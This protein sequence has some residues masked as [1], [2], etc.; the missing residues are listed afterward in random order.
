MGFFAGELEV[1]LQEHNPLP[2]ESLWNVL[3][4]LSVH[5]QQTER[6]QQAAA[7]IGQVATLP[8]PLLLQLR[9]ELNLSPI[10][11]ARLQAGIEADQ[12]FRLLMYHNYALEEAVSKANAVFS[13]VLKDRLAAGSQAESIY[14]S[15]PEL[16][17][18]DAVPS[19]VR[20][21]GRL[22]KAAK[23]A[24]LAAQQKQEESEAVPS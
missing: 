17:A 22:P 14:P 24:M 23:E 19:P 15:L 10:A 21:R 16:D 4:R 20:R 8:L 5:P 7:D 1:V 13:S 18:M 6:L 3:N 2:N 11:Y 12:F 9:Q